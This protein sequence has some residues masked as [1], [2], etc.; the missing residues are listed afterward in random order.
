MGLLHF[1]NDYV[2]Q[3]ASYTLD[4][5]VDIAYHSADYRTSIGDTEARIS[6]MGNR[7]FPRANSHLTQNSPAKNAADARQWRRKTSA[8]LVIYIFTSDQS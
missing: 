7:K 3:A 4:D 1:R 5:R 6:V 2:W 8:F